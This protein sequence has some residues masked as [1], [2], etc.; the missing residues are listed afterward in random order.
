MLTAL[1]PASLE[2]PHPHPPWSTPNPFL[3]L[4]PS[5]LQPASLTPTAHSSHLNVPGT[6][7]IGRVV[8]WVVGAVKCP[9]GCPQVASTA[10]KERQR[11]ACDD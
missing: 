5:T 1:S 7:D 2:H 8:A 3:F 6:V 10:W 11:D 9:L 4:P